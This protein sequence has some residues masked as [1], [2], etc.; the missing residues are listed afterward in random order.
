MRHEVTLHLTFDDVLDCRSAECV[1]FVRRHAEPVTPPRPSRPKVE[2][3]RCKVHKTLYV[4]PDDWNLVAQVKRRRQRVFNVLRDR[5]IIVCPVEGCRQAMQLVVID[6][7]DGHQTQC[8]FSCVS[9]LSLICRCGCEGR[10]HGKGDFSLV[11]S[12]A[13]F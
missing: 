4:V 1:E 8:T 11:A 10:N 5:H 13:S 9:S 6:V 12:W 2:R 7:R 3:L